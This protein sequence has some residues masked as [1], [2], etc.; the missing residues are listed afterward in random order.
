MTTK[1]II[2][3]SNN[4]EIDY[5]LHSYFMFENLQIENES[6]EFQQF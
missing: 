6:Q 2:G 3:L 5:L 1:P 4:S